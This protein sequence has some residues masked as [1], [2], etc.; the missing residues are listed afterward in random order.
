MIAERIDV[1][2]FK[3]FGPES[4]SFPLCPVT[5]LVGENN[6]GKS[7]VLLALDM[8]RNYSKRKV[9]KRH[10]HGHDTSVDIT[11]KVTFGTLSD[12]EKTLFRRHLGPN[13]TLTIIQTIKSSGAKGTTAAVPQPGEES[14][15]ASEMDVTE[16]KTAQYARSGIEWLDDAP[17]TK[18]DIEK[19]WKADMKVGSLDFKQWSGLPQ[20]PAPTKEQLLDKINAFWVEKWKDIPKLEES[21]GTKPLGW[22]AKLTGNLPLVVYIPALKKVSE[23]AK[24]TKASPFGSLLEWLMD[25]VAADLRQGIQAQLDTIYADAMSRLPKETDE[26]KGDQVTRL[27]LINRTLNRNLPEGFGA[28][29]SVGFEK[30]E[31]DDTIFGGAA[32][33]ANDGFLSDIGDKGQ[34][35]QRAALIAIIRSYLQLRAK[36]EAKSPALG[37]VIF[38]IEEPEIYL[39]PT[40]KR[41]L[42]GLFR[43]LGLAGDQVIYTTHDG[44]FLDVEQFEEIR[45]FRRNRSHTP[46]R[47]AVDHIS[48]PV[49]L[50]IWEKQCGKTGISLESV[51]EHLRNVYDP[52]RNEGFLSR[53]VIVCE[54]ATERAA[55]PLYMNALGYD[56]DQNGISVI[57]AGSVDLLEYFYI[58]LTE[59]AIPTYVLWDGDRPIT[60]DLSTLIDKDRADCQRKSNRNR[61]LAELFGMP[62][63]RPQSTFYFWNTDFV[64][65]SAA[66]LSRRY[67]DSVM[68]ILPNTDE[69]KGEATKLFGSD[70]KPIRARY[71]ARRAIQRGSQEGDVGKYIPR[72][73]KD[74]RDFLP[75]LKASTKLSADPSSAGST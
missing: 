59:L 73:L 71:Y 46:P 5:A 31:V 42:C 15:E 48:T 14:A 20:Q 75:G 74:I 6:T 2:N 62:L 19:L 69:V 57:D 44:Y 32:I 65:P 27:E 16:E 23:E 1:T 50:K 66:V 33:S 72:V 38:A 21:T 39:H 11:I 18:K 37:R 7:N 43:Q 70:S 67:E 26:Q 17:T 35:L 29:L 22:P 68:S 13:D 28:D 9:Q 47:T 25:S 63:P 61:H 60:P 52:F 49:L 64:T 36:L 12:A 30:P 55:L 51:R 8:F 58:L 24:A 54:G 45:V 41:S 56:L 53:S 3:S 40:I 10:F 4:V 34:G